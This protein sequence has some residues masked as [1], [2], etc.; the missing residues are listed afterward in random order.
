MTLTERGQIAAAASRSAVD[1]VDAEV[2]KRV[3]A[4]WVSRTRATLAAMI[5]VKH[6]TAVQ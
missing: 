1:R 5:D 6:A 3:G 4:D 2:A